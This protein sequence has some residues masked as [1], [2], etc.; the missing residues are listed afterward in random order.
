MSRLPITIKTLAGLFGGL[1]LIAV[2]LVE[3][4][5]SIGAEVETS[6]ASSNQPATPLP[7]TPEGKIQLGQQVIKQGRQLSRNVAHLLNQARQEKDVIQ[8]TC[9][10]DKL[11]QAN[12]STR[13]AEQRLQALEQAIQTKDADRQAHEATVLS[14]L[15]RK[16]NVLEQESGQCVGQDLYETGET[17]V[18]TTIDPKTPKEKAANPPLPDMPSLPVVPP[19]ISP[20]Q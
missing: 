10:D 4:Q 20:V 7:A 16:L 13:N 9:L 11:T 18:T 15:G 14:V 2:G 17:K 19:P 5:P 8:S 3:A 6:A 12:V 1:A